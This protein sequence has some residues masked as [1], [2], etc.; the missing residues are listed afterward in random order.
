[1][2]C[3]SE[4]NRPNLSDRK[5][6]T[7]MRSLNS[8][9]EMAKPCHFVSKTSPS[10]DNAILEDG[11]LDD[12]HT[13][14]PNS[15]VSVKSNGT[16]MTL[17]NFFCIFEAVFLQHPVPL[18][19]RDV[20]RDNLHKICFSTSPTC[21]PPLF[22]KATHKQTQ[23]KNFP[24][25]QM[26]SLHPFEV[27]HCPNMITTV[28]ECSLLESQHDNHKLTLCPDNN[29]DFE[30]TL[31]ISSNHST[32]SDLKESNGKPLLEMWLS[33][34]LIKDSNSS[35][36][37]DSHHKLMDRSS[38]SGSCVEFLEEES[39]LVA[40]IHET[41]CHDQSNLGSEYR[42]SDS[43]DSDLDTKEATLNEVTSTPP[44]KSN[45]LPLTLCAPK[46]PFKKLVSDESGY[47]ENCISEAPTSPGLCDLGEEVCDYFVCS[48]DDECCYDNE[49]DEEDESGE[50]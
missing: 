17:N 41:D 43:A 30:E 37:R 25:D 18:L 35:E 6:W 8:N 27:Q 44:C 48:Y 24:K 16:R 45:T 36:S 28:A 39:G 29:I 22:P 14:T 19:A 34:E 4:M 26:P 33:R 11:S 15:I 9:P 3:A 7:A 31:E 23:D 49:W 12:S 1:M 32:V 5:R 38:T 50:H 47:Y 13:V 2:T 21:S 40:S 20:V 10:M 46:I 42:N